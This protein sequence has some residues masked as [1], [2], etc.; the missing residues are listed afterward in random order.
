MQEEP[1]ADS[2]S[3]SSTGSGVAAAAASSLGIEAA[4]ARYVKLVLG[5][6][7]GFVHV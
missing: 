2:V 3:P 4:G 6:L 5:H 1:T 7:T